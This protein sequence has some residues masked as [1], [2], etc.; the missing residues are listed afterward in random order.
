MGHKHRR[1][2]KVDLETFV[3]LIVGVLKQFNN[4]ETKADLG[5][6]GGF[7]NKLLEN[8]TDNKSES[9][10]QN[11]LKVLSEL[12]TSDL[13]DSKVFDLLKNINKK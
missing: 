4:K 2:D 10:K 5:S 12:D 13:Q 8:L 3:P 11:L 6:A 7:G 9:L 1:R